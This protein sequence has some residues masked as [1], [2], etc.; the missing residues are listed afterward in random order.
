MKS[1]LVSLI[2]VCLAF[3]SFSQTSLVGVYV[4]DRDVSRRP[5]PYQ[6]VREADVM[7]SKTIW[8]KIDLR[9]KINH[10]L[11]YPEAPRGERMSLID[12]LLYAI[13]KGLIAYTASADEIDEFKQPTTR[14]EIN[15]KFD[16]QDK[17]IMVED[18]ETGQLVERKQKGVVKSNDVKE[19]L[20]KELWFFDKQRSVLDVRIIGICPIRCYFKDDD[21]EQL[22]PMFTKLFWIYFPQAREWF[23]NHLV[24]NPYNDA[25]HM[26][27]DDLF[28]KR[29]F[30]SYIVK[31]SNTF[32][33]RQINEYTIGVESL[34]EAERIKENIFNFEHDLWEY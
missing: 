32:N 33:D 5:V 1:A 22:N 7:W 11:Y 25:D 6:F 24:F 20:V 17:T 13:D 30:S 34:L 9:E 3:G 23:A 2:L 27:F 21:T 28:F 4:K 8:R 19:Y 31:E 15:V 29:Y 10:P 14:A 12:L 18:V 16:A 26:T